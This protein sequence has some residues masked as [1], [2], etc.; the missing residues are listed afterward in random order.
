MDD[1]TNILD[2]KEVAALL[3]TKISTVYKMTMRGVLPFYK[4]NGGKLYFKRDEVE[5]WVFRDRHA[6]RHDLETA[7]RIIGSR[8]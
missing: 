5:A 4:P 6:S 8:R 2:A 3:R 1:G 7:A